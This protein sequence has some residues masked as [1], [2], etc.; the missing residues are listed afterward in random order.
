[1]KK[2]KRVEEPEIG[3]D[4]KKYVPIKNNTTLYV[5]GLPPDITPAVFI[6]FFSKCGIIK[7]NSEGTNQYCLLFTYSTSSDLISLLIGEYKYKIYRDESGKPKGDGIIT[8]FRP[9]SITLAMMHL[10]GEE[11]APGY[12]V[13]LSEAKFEWK[14]GAKPKKPKPAN[15]KKKGYDQSMFVFIINYLFTNLSHLTNYF[16][17]Q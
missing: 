2:R 15:K 10:D 3:E 4:G 16:S 8:Y 12:K 6:Q 1:M 5:E 7:K 17:F 13:K 14:E 9:E 11:I